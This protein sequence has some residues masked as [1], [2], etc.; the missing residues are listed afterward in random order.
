VIL[1][2]KWDFLVRERNCQQIYSIKRHKANKLLPLLSA[3]YGAEFAD[4]EIKEEKVCLVR[5]CK[6]HCKIMNKFSEIFILPA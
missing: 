2:F 1:S 5:K 4:S 6:V 3:S